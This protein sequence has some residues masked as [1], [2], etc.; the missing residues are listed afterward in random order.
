[1]KLIV[2]LGNP[3]K[4]YEETR[5]NCGF[6]A[7]SSL[8][9]ILDFSTFKL[10]KKFNSFVSKGKIDGKKI[11]LARPQT[12][13]NESGRAVFAIAFFYKIK[14]DDIWVIYDDL[15]LPLGKIRIRLG[16]S[17]GGHK[18]V[19]SIIDNLKTDNFVRFRIGITPTGPGALKIPAEKFVLQKFRKGEKENIIK[20]I[21]RA[22]EAIR[23]ALKKGIK[24]AM[25]K[26]N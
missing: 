23:F 5:H 8:R 6:M 3:G 14:A 9:S 1:M 10:K 2:G 12:F 16:G 25:N 22:A 18:G 13:M 21:H 20:T 24:E 4:E 7:I 15:D 26:Y 11:I 19:Q 17:S